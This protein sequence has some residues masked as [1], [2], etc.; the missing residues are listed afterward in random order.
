M[1]PSGL[2]YFRAVY[3]DRLV[4]YSL[5]Q[6]EV[7]ETVDVIF[8]DNDQSRGEET[9]QILVSDLGSIVGVE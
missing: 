7:P 9:A 5:W 6:Y 1:V 2:E 8:L 4:E 3:K